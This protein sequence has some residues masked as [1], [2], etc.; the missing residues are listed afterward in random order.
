[1]RLLPGRLRPRG[2]PCPA[3][4]VIEPRGWWSSATTGLGWSRLGRGGVPLHNADSNRRVCQAL[5]IVGAT[6]V[7]GVRPATAQGGRVTGS[8]WFQTVDLRPLRRD[9]VPFGATVQGADGS[10]RTS[11]GQRVSCTEGEPWCGFLTSGPRTVARPLL[12]DVAIAAWGL[13]RGVSL[14]ANLRARDDLGESG[15]S[16]P[17]IEDRFD[18]LEA[19]VEV[20]RERGRLRAGRQWVMNALGATNFDGATMLWRGTRLTTEVYGGRALVQGLAEPY[21]SPELGRV[22]D[23]PPDEE[24]ALMG[25]RLRFKRR[26]GLTLQGIY[27]RAVRR[28]R[29]G[30]VA[31]RASLS[32]AWSWR[33]TAV[34]ANLVQDVAANE[35]NELHVRA[36]RQVWPRVGVSLEGRRTRPYFEL[37]T[38]WGAFAP[39]SFDEGRA[40]LSWR[41]PEGSVSIGA[42][43]AYRRYEDANTGLQFAPLRSDGWRAG[44]DAAWTPSERFV[45]SA[46]YGIDIGTGASQSDASVG[47]R[48]EVTDRLELGV[49]A[50]A[51]ETIYEF[52]VGSGRVLGGLAT[53]SWRL[54]AETRLRFD[55]GLYRH[56]LAG[57]ALGQDWSQ[58]RAS[59]RLEWAI[60]SD[61]GHAAGSNRSDGGAAAGRGS[62]GSG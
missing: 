35:P 23:L 43:G 52:R 34:Q 55:S 51:L 56:R 61:P 48:W 58:R 47:A 8:T 7:A 33:G 62:G 3:L 40:A 14:H 50:S 49:A 2:Q 12:H 39:V 27:Q 53:G 25:A 30:L 18:A 38:I 60:G 29:G 31:E 44:V 28:D 41:S 6:L 57:D 36:N 4:P 10:R 22:D 13:G 42:S 45:A 46:T 19:Y 5:L 24:A 11:S 9:S 26:S 17:R 32:G 1:M 54:N 37:W 15:A 59:L 20:D 21:T 16:W